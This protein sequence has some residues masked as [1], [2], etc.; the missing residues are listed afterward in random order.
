MT[1]AHNSETAGSEPSWGSVD[2]SRLP[3]NAFATMNEERKYPHH[4]VSGGGELDDDGRY[5]SGT[6]YLHRGGLNA[7]WQAANGARSGQ[8]A[9]S[10]IKAHL[11]AHRKALGLGSGQALGPDVPAGPQ[12]PLSDTEGGNHTTDRQTAAPD[13]SQR[14]ALG[15]VLLQLAEQAGESCQYDAI[16]VQPGHIRKAD[17]TDSEWLIPADVLQDAADRG[18][19][20]A[21]S[22]YV[23][24][25][26]MFGFG[27]P[28]TPSVRDLGGVVTDA[29]WDPERE[30]VRGTIRLYDT[31]AGQLMASLYDQILAD[32]EAGRDVPP[33]GLSIA[34]YR[35]YRYDKESGKKVW[36]EINK[37]DSVDLVYE[38]GAAGYIRQALSSA[39]L[40]SAAL[41]SAAL[42]AAGRSG[43]P[44][45]LPTESH[46][47]TGG[48]TMEE[49][50]RTQ[51]DVVQ[52][53]SPDPAVSSSR[54]QPRDLAE[55]LALSR[56][57]GPDT[58]HQ[59]AQ[60]NENVGQVSV[61]EATPAQPQS[62]LPRDPD[63]ELLEIRQ[64]LA[65]IQEIVAD[66]SAAVAA[67]A[68]DETIE[69]MGDPPRE[70]TLYGGHSSLER[71]QLAAEALIGGERPSAGVRPLTGIRE[72]YMLL[73]G[74][75]ELTGRYNPDRVYL[76]NVTTSTMANIVADALNKR[77]IN[78]FQSY[79]QWWAPGVTVQDFAT[80][81]DVKWITLGGVAELPT[82]AEGAVYTEMTWDDQK[83]EASFVKKG[84]YL[85]ITLETIDKD[86]TGRVMAAPR[87]LAQAA[88][89]TLGKSIAAIFTDNTGAGPTM[90]D[91]DE[92]FHSNHSNLG[93][94]ALSYDA[95][96]TTKIAMMKQTELNSDERLGAL[97]RPRLLWV[98]IDL[99][100]T[101]VEILAAGEGEIGSADYHVNPDA[102]AEGLTARIRSAR[103]RVITV[104]FWT[105][106]DNWAAQADPNL[107]PS[108]GLGFRYGRTPEIFS[109][110]DP[111]AGL[112]FTND[113]MPIK[114][115]FFYAVGPTDYRGLYKHN[116]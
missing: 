107:Y 36:T 78:M 1:L 27:W 37:V 46:H 79:D 71:V 49:E 104:P 8:Q 6:M 110:A 39:A 52:D 59:P 62:Q 69:G 60:E 47:P 12:A 109:V 68:E 48:H 97:T 95:W 106:T 83:E 93:S 81:Q 114:V 98:P 19:F 11:N 24:H 45:R 74:D 115:R 54:A 38:P 113:T 100:D 22:H 65:S 29:R 7:A 89:M 53:A 112:M 2:K 102:A 33:I 41:S 32:R 96:Q 42:S 82:V 116:V 94:T 44:A 9:S 101:A 61:S 15:R 31:E 72:L 77:V 103:S 5:T 63:P 92:L 18:L 86:D 58:S 84:G 75:Y 57:E 64:N 16:L 3:D 51:T 13:S 26:E 111:R 17:G 76:A 35:K 85:G 73:S 90:S 87:A 56:A 70:P 50:A 34:A 20:S 108:I 66:L 25:P 14:V 30:A 80:L 10:A 105:D 21:V 4:W 88:W 40:S 67:Q 23:D 99:E 43:G 28:Q 55:G 91:S